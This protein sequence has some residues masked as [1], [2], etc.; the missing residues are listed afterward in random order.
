MEQLDAAARMF[1]RALDR[2]DTHEI[3]PKPQSAEERANVE[4]FNRRASDFGVQRPITQR[5]LLRVTIRL[6][7]NLGAQ[8]KNLSLLQLQKEVKM[9]VEIS[10]RVADTLLF[11]L[12]ITTVLTSG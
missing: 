3:Q 4:F 10:T 7:R 12:S 5:E 8:F 1:E 2:S 11:L 9:R 6:V